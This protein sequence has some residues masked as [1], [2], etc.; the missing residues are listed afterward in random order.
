MAPLRWLTVAAALVLAGCATTGIGS[1]VERGRDF[2][3]YRTY[4]WGQADPLPTPDPRLD[5]NA[6]FQDYLQG[7]VER[8][9]ARRGYERDSSGEPDLLIH[10]HASVATRLQIDHGIAGPEQ[11]SGDGCHPAAV[12]ATEMATL[13]F[14][15]VDGRSG[16]VVWRGWTHHDLADLTGDRVRVG[17]RLGESVTQMFANL[18]GGQR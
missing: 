3:Q 13:V 16:R 15:V 17:R 11:C 2:S 14:D 7:A 9:L 6:H 18:P 12:R 4:D 5:A 10:F 8:G 1:H